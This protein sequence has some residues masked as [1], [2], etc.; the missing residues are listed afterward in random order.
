MSKMKNELVIKCP[1][2]D[3]VLNSK[4]SA[5]HHFR[6]SH[7][8]SVLDYFIETK[9]I[10]YVTCQ[11]PGCNN[12]VG[13]QGGW[14]PNKTCCHPHQL[15]LM[16]IEGNH[17][18]QSKN[19][20][21]DENGDDVIMKGITERGNN[22]FSSK[23]RKYDENGNDI[24]ARKSME[25]KLLS[26]IVNPITYKSGPRNLDPSRKSEVYVLIPSDIKYVKV[27]RSINSESR[28]NSLSEYV[29]VKDV[30]KFETDEVTAAK[31]EAAVHKE[32]CK[33]ICL[34]K[35]IV[36]Y[37]EWYSIDCLDSIIKFIENYILQFND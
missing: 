15:S 6:Y 23:N 4:S 32:F 26:G 18:Y 36:N 25:S 35:S 34:D 11:Y 1:W 37:S 21:R 2:C 3:R 17:W 28:I 13:F 12:I 22:P 10:E 29:K 19:R 8:K 16:A 20:K 14:K 31:I 30:V 5:S 33:F 7:D 24:I 9:G 27:G